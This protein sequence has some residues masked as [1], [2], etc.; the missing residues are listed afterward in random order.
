MI[1]KVFRFEGFAKFMSESFDNYFIENT[2]EGSRLV[3]YTI[4]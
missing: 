4:G 3:L 1:I 2:S